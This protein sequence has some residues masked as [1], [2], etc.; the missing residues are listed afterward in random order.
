MSQ[1]AETSFVSLVEV[2]E[3]VESTICNDRVAFVDH[4]LA[5]GHAVEMTIVAIDTENDDA[6]VW[7]M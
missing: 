4:G 3:M 5:G 1:V 7:E 2:D 6:F